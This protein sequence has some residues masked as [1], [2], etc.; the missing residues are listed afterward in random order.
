[1]QH[2]PDRRDRRLR[3]AGHRASGFPSRHSV[4]VPG[5]RRHRSLGDGLTGPQGPVDLV[6]DSRESTLQ[7]V[8]LEQAKPELR[9]RRERRHGV[10]EVLE[11]HLADDGD[12]R[13][14]QR[15]CDLGARDR[16]ADDDAALL[17]DDESGPCPARSR[18]TNEPP[19]LPLVSTSTA[20]T[21]SPASCAAASVSPTA[22]TCGSVKITR[23]EAPPS[24]RRRTSLPRIASA[25]SRAWYFPMCVSSA[26][27]LTSPTA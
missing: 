19:A 21:V 25:A 26:R 15:L 18:P 14:V 20:R 10:P 2:R 7:P 27:P 16:R 1:M 4:G 9:A 6:S 11:R 17:V 23:G 3:A 13:R 24:E 22:P 12:R 8:G 5:C